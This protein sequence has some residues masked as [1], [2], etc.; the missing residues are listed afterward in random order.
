LAYVRVGYPEG[1]FRY[2]EVWRIRADGTG[3]RRVSRPGWA[4]E[5]PAWSPNGKRLTYTRIWDD[6]SEDEV[7]Y[8]VYVVRRDGFETRKLHDG[9]RST[10]SS[11][12][13]L[14]AF[15]YNATLAV[16]GPDSRGL[17]VSAETWLRISLSSPPSVT[18]SP[19]STR[20]T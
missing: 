11:D 18:G 17:R 2:S 13:R 4:A 1:V 19:S 7:R 3:N 12:G 9:V 16:I 8:T 10:W 5:E 15:S 20:G 6:G 14:I